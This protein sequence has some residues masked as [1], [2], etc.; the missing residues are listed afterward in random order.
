MKRIAFINSREPRCGVYQYGQ[1]L[2][3]ILKESELFHTVMFDCPAAI[4]PATHLDP[5][6]AV[7]YNIHP[8]IPNA[9]YHAPFKTRAKQVGIFHDGNMS[10]AMDAWIYSDPTQKSYGNIHMIGRPLPLWMPAMYRPFGG[11]RPVVGLSGLVGAWATNMV[12]TVLQQLPNAK[13]RLHLPPSDHCDPSGGLARA[14]GDSCRKLSGNPDDMEI[15]HDF[16]SEFEL[17][18]WLSDNDLNC[19]IRSPAGSIGVS[20]ALDLALAV[21]KPIAINHHVMFRHIATVTPSVCVENLPLGEILRAGINPLV[22]HYQRNDRDHV[23]EELELILGSL[24]L[25]NA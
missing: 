3:N 22:P 15:T 1:R 8:G 21:R 5:F 17:L 12:T 24:L 23:R 16:L 4:D 9:I 10:Q 7:I 2:Y 25:S 18:S 6:D 14:V 19:Y 11:D 13:I 20:S